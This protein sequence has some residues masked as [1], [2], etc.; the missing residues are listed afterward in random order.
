LVGD[1]EGPSMIDTLIL[2]K[3]FSN[4]HSRPK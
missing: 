4:D 1:V 3:I 2:S